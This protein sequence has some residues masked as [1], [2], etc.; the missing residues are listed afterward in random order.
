M[1]GFW[2]RLKSEWKDLP[3]GRKIDE[4]GFMNGVSNL[5]YGWEFLRRHPDYRAD[6]DAYRAIID[7]AKAHV[8][9][10]MPYS[11][12]TKM[13]FPPMIPEDEGNYRR[14]LKR[15][16]FE[17]NVDPQVVH[18]N[19]FYPQKWELKRMMPYNQSYTDTI[20]FLPVQ[21]GFPVVIRCDDDI[22]PFLEEIGGESIPRV[23]AIVSDKA[24]LIFDL[25]APR[26]KQAKAAK[27]ILDDIFKQN[28]DLYG[29]GRTSVPKKQ[30]DHLIRHLRVLDLQRAYPDMTNAQIAEAVG[31]DETVNGTIAAQQGQRYVEQA[32]HAR[33]NYRFFLT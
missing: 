32:I 33:N 5:V 10:V 18:A 20:E 19:E 7:E 30:T 3:D 9:K 12:W 16:I 1:K 6:Y 13:Y 29:V 17:G 11:K 4:Y 15:I 14:W 8:G 28:K 22:A 24:V 21:S 26:A 2:V 23:N 25:N 27:K 31:Y